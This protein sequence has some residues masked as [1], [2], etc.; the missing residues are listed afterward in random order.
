MASNVS[1]LDAF[2]MHYEQFRGSVHA[3]QHLDGSDV[4]LLELLGENLESFRQIVDQNPEAFPDRTEW[5]QLRANIGVMVIDLRTI[6]ARALESSHQGRPP[7]VQYVSDGRPGRPHAVI[8]P[9]FLAWAYTQRPTSGIATFLGLGRTT[10]REALLEY[11]IVTPSS[12][13]FPGGTETDSGDS[14]QE[15]DSVN[16]EPAPTANEP[17]PS[18]ATSGYLSTID[19]DTLDLAL[20]DFK[21]R[22]PK[23]GIKTLQ[24]MLRVKGHIVQNERIRQSLIRIDPIHRVFERVTIKRRKYKVPGPNALWHHDGHHALIRWGIIVHGFIDGYSRLITGL[25]AANNNCASTV[26]LLFLLAATIYGVPLWLRGDHGT[27]NIWVAAFMEFARGSGRGSYLWG[28]SVHN[29]RIERLWGDV[30]AN[31]TST[32]DERFTDLELNAALNIHNRNHIW[33]LHLL[34]LPIINEEM[35]FWYRSWNQH[36]IA[37]KGGA[38][39]SPE[40]MFGFDMLVHSFRGDN[41]QSF[42]MTEDDLELFGVD[43]EGLHNETLL[44]TLHQ[45]YSQDGATSW[46]GNRGPPPSL[47]DIPVNPPPCLMSSEETAALLHHIEPLPR[48]SQQDHIRNLW[49]NGLA[50]ARHIRPDEF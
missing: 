41:L 13:P 26:L 49:I 21:S 30:R 45:N 29:V 48:S 34:F 38:S 50:Y 14:E 46:I 42:P 44:R 11:G 7:V 31:I 12:N 25:R 47:N 22:Y 4:F 8:N 10:V 16:P 5:E 33:L 15:A 17:G 24:G 9:N 18:S 32:W 37:V 2:R 27:E 43:W 3:S 28:R 20:L 19:D 39:R 1:L 35:E 36:K 23:A 40:D 6:H